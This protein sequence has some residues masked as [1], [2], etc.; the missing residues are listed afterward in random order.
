MAWRAWPAVATRPRERLPVASCT[1]VQHCGAVL[2][3]GPPQSGKTA[4]LECLALHIKKQHQNADAIYINVN[5]LEGG[6]QLD[7][8]LRQRLGATLAQLVHGPKSE[9]GASPQLPTARYN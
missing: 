9:S 4:L 2:I 1:Q 5:R 7:D 6:G 3:K 8:L